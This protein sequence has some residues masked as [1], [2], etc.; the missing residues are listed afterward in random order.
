MNRTKVRK[1]F[2]AL[3][4]L[5]CL[6]PEESKAIMPFLNHELCQSI[7]ECI[8]NGMCNPTI[9][10]E[11]QS[12]LATKLK[13]HKRSFRYLNN[14]EELLEQNPKRRNQILERKKRTLSKVSDCIGD[15]FNVAIPILSDYLS[16]KRKNIRTKLENENKNKNE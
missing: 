5:A 12:D 1:A 4:I 2:P 3:R 10:K 13:K 8:E 15:V 6:T 16:C 9:P 7:L 14:K 11:I